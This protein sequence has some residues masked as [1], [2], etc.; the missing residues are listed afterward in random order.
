MKSYDCVADSLELGGLC[1]H[2][3]R[4]AK[5]TWGVS[6]SG[7]DMIPAEETLFKLE[8][9]AKSSNVTGAGLKHY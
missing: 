1:F 7:V 6:A 5:N 3:D 4:E 8:I 9:N 2:G